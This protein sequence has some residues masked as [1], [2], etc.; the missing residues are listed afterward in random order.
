VTTPA[1]WFA[2]I[3]APLDERERV[4]ADALLRAH[5]RLENAQLHQA[6][7]WREAAVI[8][9]AEDRD[10]AAWEFEEEERQ[11]LWQQAADRIGE[12][13]LFA[14]LTAVTAALAGA[15]G[16]AAQAAA[17][18][19]G[20]ADPW[21]AEAAGVAALLAVHQREL[22]VAAGETPDHWFVRRC[23]LFEAGR[24]PLGSHRGRC[25]LF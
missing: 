6:H 2:T 7:D 5:P 4:L 20:I 19:R 1:R 13:A 10:P 3:G 16:A 22:A 15:V 9:A 21:F 11:R 17:A 8:V 12:D 18:R 24:W 25:A 14:Q 23:A